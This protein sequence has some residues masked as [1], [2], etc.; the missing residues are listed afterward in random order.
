MAV[1]VSSLF[2]AINCATPLVHCRDIALKRWF[3]RLAKPPSLEPWSCRLS[4]EN[5]VPQ[6]QVLEISPLGV[7][8]GAQS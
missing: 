4:P 3:C 7:L 2:L 1:P 6:I 5:L 8:K